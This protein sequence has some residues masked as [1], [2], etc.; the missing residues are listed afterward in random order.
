MSILLNSKS[1]GNSKDNINE[2]KYANDLT[3]YI[4][5]NTPMYD[6]FNKDIVLIS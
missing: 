1:C 4:M 2:I 6:S 5:K 3:I